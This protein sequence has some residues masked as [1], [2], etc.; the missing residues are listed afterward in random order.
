MPSKKSSKKPQL[1]KCGTCNTV[2]HNKSTCTQKIET[3]AAAGPSASPLKFFIHHVNV[4]SPSSPHV[5]N[6]K[7]E[8]SEV[9]KHV[10][11][12][13]PEISTKLFQTYHSE[14]DLN[15]VKPELDPKAP[16]TNLF[17]D[18]NQGESFSIFENNQSLKQETPK[19]KFLNDFSVRNLT[20]KF[21]P[22][23]AVVSAALIL[24]T[25]FISAS[26][27]KSYYRSLSE[28]KASVVENSTAGFLALQD[29]SIALRTGS[30]SEADNSTKTALDKFNIALGTL[31]EKHT[32]L[33]NILSIVPVLNKEI[34]SRQKVLLAGQE[35]A[36]GNSYLLSAIKAMEGS[37]EPFTAK[38]NV[39]VGALK[40][41]NPN[42]EQAV[43]NLNSVDINL[44]PFE[45]QEQFKELRFIFQTL[46]SDFKKIAGL[47][48]TLQEIFGGM[49]VRR[50]LLVFQNPHEL[51]PTGGFIG[52]FA[53]MD[54]KDGKIVK[55]DVPPGGS[56]DLQG[57]L[58][59]YL[60][61]P[62]PL[63]IS[64]KRWEFQDANWFP[65]FPASAEK[66]LW[67]YNRSRNVTADGVIAINASVLESI[68]GVVGSITDEKRGLVLTQ[69]DAVTTIQK[70]VE[71]GPEK[72]T[73]KPKQI[74]AD[75]APKIFNS[76]E[77]T[78]PTT[79]LPLL[80]VLESSLEKKDIQA[81]FTSA[82]SEKT[83]AALGWSGKL[84]DISPTTDY[85][86]VVNTNLQGQKSDSKIQQTITH[87]AVI[88]EDGSIT[89]TVIIK[90][91][92]TGNPGEKY[93][94]APNF[95]YLRIY[96]PKG[97]ELLS[98]QG[99]TWPPEE[100]FR[101]PENWYKFDPFLVSRE[102][103]IKIDEE[104][105]TRVTNEF[106][107]TSF[108]NWIVTEPGET[109]T[110]VFTYRLPFKV[111]PENNSAR[112]IWEKALSTFDEPILNY[113]I[114]TQKQSGID[115]SFE[116][117]IIFPEYWNPFWQKGSN[118]VTAR[119]G[120][121]ITPHTLTKDSVWSVLMK[122]Q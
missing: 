67:F 71:D 4:P 37:T 72:K 74:L 23:K 46:V 77:N 48:D 79:I 75:L 86:M 14:K 57:Q 5:V 70:I 95:N 45:Y 21:L 36:L 112:T 40:L 103:Q 44:L 116:S 26:P 34:Q 63:T 38:L 58:P 29:S 81:Y 52:S 99:F 24:L 60:I 9:W 111:L 66:L 88:A 115:S 122:K 68:L 28:T 114:V 80:A 107:K 108:G 19:T 1:R 13:S 10:E 54:V 11:S 119:N 105:G 110:V 61:P 55:L 85:L 31:G 59:D 93:Y 97:S 50:Y 89:D 94:G 2:G 113:Q 73:G 78:P 42:Y 22:R 90:R 56:Y 41:A 51:R 96:V 98:A 65:D 121:K 33:Q 3:K 20:V 25:I 100:K 101:A 35:I 39:L 30:I 82:E 109:S 16:K 15:L 106:E 17:V 32:I 87:Q 43:E 49:G 8:A 47:N 84:A 92:H 104:S 53:V 69:K 120:I 118:L 6:L 102:I 7:N 91:E 76:L 83:V 62:L 18:L 64:N 117:Q 27:V 12:S